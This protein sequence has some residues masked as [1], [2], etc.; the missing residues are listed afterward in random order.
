VHFSFASN[1]PVDGLFHAVERT[2]KDFVIVRV[3]VKRTYIDVQ[4]VDQVE[5][6]ALDF[7][8]VILCIR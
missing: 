4:I 3:Q 7:I 1:Q 8:D 6:Q 5:T 2:Q